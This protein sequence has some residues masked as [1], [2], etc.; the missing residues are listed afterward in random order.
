MNSLMTYRSVT[1]YAI[2]CNL[3]KKNDNKENKNVTSFFP[4]SIDQYITLCSLMF[5]Q[6]RQCIRGKK[7]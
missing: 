4:L 3:E 2:K 1:L 7:M 5:G 6:E